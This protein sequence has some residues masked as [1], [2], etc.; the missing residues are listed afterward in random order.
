MGQ[1]NGHQQ[2]AP[3]TASRGVSRLAVVA[4]RHSLTFGAVVVDLR[5]ERVELEVLGAVVPVRLRR[6]RVV[7]HVPA[8]AL[9]HSLQSTD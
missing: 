7:Q 6:P 2:S 5:D 9:T 8:D 1:R 4:C 3:T